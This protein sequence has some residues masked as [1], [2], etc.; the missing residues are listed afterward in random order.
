M[1]TATRLA[2]PVI[3]RVRALNPA[4][5]LVR[6]RALRA[7]ERRA[8]A[9]ARRRR[10]IL[11][12]EFEEDLVARVRAISARAAVAELDAAHASAA[13]A[14]MR[15]RGCSS[16]SRTATG[17]PPLTRYATL[18]VGDERRVVG[19]TEASRGCKH[20]C[21][22][23]PIVP[24]YDG[25]FRVVPADVVLADVAGAGRRRRAAHH[26]R[27]SRLLQRH[28]RTPSA[29][30]E[31]VRARVPGRQLRRHDQGRAPA[32]ACATLLPLLR[33]TGCAFV[34]SAVESVDD[35]VLAQLEKGHTRADFERGGG[36]VPRGRPARCRRPSSRSRRGRRSRAICELLHDDRPAR[37]RRARRADPARDPPAR[38]AGI[39]AAGADEMRALRRRVRS[40]RR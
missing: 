25:R 3:D 11:G 2:L 12:G 39:A 14:Q 24:V 23:C 17:L 7:A 29:I 27:R 20:R 30:V 36:A 21:R 40:A 1:H 16:A 4:A 22:H 6:L 26:V 32:A 10:T 18:Q 5:R 38:P 35:D 9:R 8:P 15:S 31:R 13:L 28:P 34:T 33:D 19:Y 37:S